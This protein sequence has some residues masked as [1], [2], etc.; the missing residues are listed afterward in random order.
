MKRLLP[1]ALLTLTAAL[2]LGAAPA[3]AASASTSASTGDAPV[4]RGVRTDISTAFALPGERVFPEGIAA[5]PRS[6]TVYVGSYTNG[7]VYRARPGART[8][9]VFLPPGTDGRHT[10]NGLRV[11]GHG[12]L[13]VTDS[14]AGVSVYDTRSGARLA[15]FEIPGSGPRFLNDLAVTP[16][17]TAYLTDSVRAVVYR[18]TPEQLAAGSGP[19][20][21]AYDLSGLLTPSPA[22]SFSLNGITADPA[23][24]FLLT[25]DMTAGDLH[26]ID[27]V[28]GAVSRV[29]LTGGDLK[30][31]DGLDLAPGGVLRAAQNT[32]NT[33]SRWQVS[34][35]GTRARL[36]RTVT[37]PA[38][39]IPTTL[40]QVPGRTLVVRSQFDKDGG[41]LPSTGGAPTQFTVASVRGF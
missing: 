17:G 9:E 25:V 22:G 3:P 31:A 15:H 18:V 11:D 27:P 2:T 4:G 39:Q 8:A 29:A 7:A 30:T 5:D 20:L 16:D 13:W 36:V 19:L 6:G 1:V 12:R 24:R 41:P 34:A 37:D 10:A 14:T 26:R 23:G 38:L 32:R 35:D 33:L 28:S 21:P 40:V